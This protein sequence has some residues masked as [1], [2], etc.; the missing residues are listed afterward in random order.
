MSW[1]FPVSGTKMP[2]SVPFSYEKKNVGVLRVQIPRTIADAVSWSH[3]KALPR[4]PEPLLMEKY[5]GAVLEM[6]SGSPPLRGRCQDRPDLTLLFLSRTQGELTQRR[7]LSPDLGRP[8]RM[9]H[10]ILTLTQ[11]TGV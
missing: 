5:L 9:K 10:R 8:G 4:L 3:R 6:M 7:I 1:S 2:K 11:W